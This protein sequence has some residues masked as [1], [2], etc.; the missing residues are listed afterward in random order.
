MRH[1]YGEKNIKTAKSIDFIF[2]LV[3]LKIFF[4]KNSFIALFH[5]FISIIVFFD[6]FIS[7]TLNFLENLTSNSLLSI[8]NILKKFRFFS[9][10]DSRFKGLLLFSKIVIA[11]SKCIL[12]HFCLL[13][14]F[15]FI[16]FAFF[17]VCFFRSLFI[18]FLRSIKKVIFFFRNQLL[19]FLFMILFL[20]V[21]FSF[22]FFFRF[23]RILK[24]LFFAL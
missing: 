4:M 16:F 11:L 18:C 22:V 13:I 19:F 6:F 14:S 21:V 24:R 9:S 17:V 3:L 10:V 2:L 5:L 7:R 15:Y 20:C 8:S 1:K 12:R 23:F